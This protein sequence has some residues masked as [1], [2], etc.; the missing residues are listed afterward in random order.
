VLAII[1]KIKNQVSI[2]NVCLR[3]LLT[4]LSKM[5]SFSYLKM[6]SLTLPP[7]VALLSHVCKQQYFRA[8]HMRVFCMCY[9]ISSQPHFQEAGVTTP[10]CR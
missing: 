2:V 8:Q 7:P 4:H 9:F 1:L 6:H 10:I 5:A 3:L